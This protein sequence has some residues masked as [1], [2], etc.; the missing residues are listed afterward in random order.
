M[1]QKRFL[2]VVDMQHDFVD[3]SLGTPEAQAIISNVQSKI[4]TGLEEEKYDKIIFT[5]DTHN[6]NYLDTFEGKRLPVPHCIRNT[7][8]QSLLDEVYSIKHLSQYEKKII[9][10]E[11]TTFS[12]TQWDLNA[13][14]LYSDNVT[15][16]EIEFTIIGLCTDICVVSNALML[17][18]LF[19]KAQIIV[20][21]SCCAGTTP[22]KHEAA[23]QVM[24]SCL[25]D[26]IR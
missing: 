16:E 19:P 2:I 23:L 11:K 10:L 6:L 26:V 7:K 12:I 21:A 25:I 18:T 1:E 3:G 9:V 17:R 5:M 24:E 14:G 20:D 22:E 15:K 8:G 4:I 13:H